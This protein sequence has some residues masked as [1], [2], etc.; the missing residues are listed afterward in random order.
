MDILFVILQYFAVVNYRVIVLT[1]FCKAI[2]PVVKRLQVSVLWKLNF[3][4]IVVNRRC[5][6]FHF[7]VDETPIAVNNW[8]GSLKLYCFVKI[9]KGF[10]KPEIYQ[11]LNKT[12]FPV[13][14]KQHARLC[15]YTA[16]FLSNWMAWVK[17]ATASSWCSSLS[18][19]RPLPLNAGAYAWSRFITSS[20]SLRASGSLSPPIFSLIVPRWCNAE[21]LFG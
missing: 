16:F 7:S 17:S 11:Q 2:G 19:T 1:N 13:F 6:L 14:L 12:Y 15:Q 3:V 10:F 21:T 5:E 8:I 4:R 9:K 20:K 18:Q